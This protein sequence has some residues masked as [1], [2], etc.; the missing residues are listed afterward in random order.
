MA[1]TC[2]GGRRSAG[3]SV[4]FWLRA[5]RAFS[6]P[7]S[8][9]PLLVA[10]AAALPLGRWRWDVLAA[11]LLGVLGLAAAGN[12]LNDYFDY[13]R[14][15]DVRTDEP[16]RPGRLLVRGELA[17][18]QVLRAT[19]IALAVSSVAGLYLARVSGP[20]VLAFV[21]LGLIGAY[22]Y[23]GPPLQLKYR[24]LGELCVFLTFGPALMAGAAYAQLGTVP[25][26]VL[27]LS[28]PMGF[29]VTSVLTAN[30]LRDAAEDAEA[31]IRTLAHVM[32][33]GGMAALC[34]GLALGA[35]LGIAAVGIARGV[36]LTAACLLTLPLAAPPLRAMLRGESPP[37]V[38]VQ[39]VRF[40]LALGATALAA[41][42]RSGGL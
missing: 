35:P 23:T 28:V 10:S 11:G 24:A 5:V 16:G 8:L 4:R 34:V 15:V 12:L 40:V 39:M 6:F 31:G 42:I 30:N 29:A 1:Q 2:G 33:P 13:V 21:L 3:A 38:D 27:A 41:L 14:G 25:G 7:C 9:M 17:P 32:G 36:P 20:G 19:A 37:D 26:G 18:R 22:A